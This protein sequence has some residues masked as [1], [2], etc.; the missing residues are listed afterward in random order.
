MMF[1]RT[2]DRVSICCSGCHTAYEL[3]LEPALAG[4]RSR[5]FDAPP[6]AP[7]YCPFCGA[8]GDLERS[9]EGDVSGRDVLDPL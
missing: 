4:A 2:G 9:E 6:K 3:E 7:T 1:L 5:R 8:K